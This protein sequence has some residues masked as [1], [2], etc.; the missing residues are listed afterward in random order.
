MLEMLI[1]SLGPIKHGGW[2]W[3]ELLL[4]LFKEK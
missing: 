2:N 3:V 4:E 1:Q